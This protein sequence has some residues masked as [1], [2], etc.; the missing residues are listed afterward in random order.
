MPRHQCRAVAAAVLALALVA[1]GCGSGN[2]F[3]CDSGRLGSHCS[4]RTKEEDA[5]RALADH[6]FDRAVALLTELVAAEHEKDAPDY[7]FNTLLAAAY[8]GRGGVSVLDLAT[9]LTTAGADSGSD[10][11]GDGSFLETLKPYL[12]S[13]AAPCLDHGGDARPFAD[14]VAD[15][16]GAVSAA[17]GVPQAELAAE[18]PAA[19]ART[20]AF[21]LMLYQFVYG[22]MKL[23]QFTTSVTG[24]LDPSLLATMTDA[25]AL[26]ILD[27]LAAAG[28]VP[29][30]T[31][32]E[33]QAKIAAA[34]AEIAAGD[35]T[36]RDKLAAYLA[37]SGTATAPATGPDPAAG[38]GG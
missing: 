23:S 7:R 33:V 12:P 26:A 29:G 1:P 36:S 13:P 19:F 21:E 10:G 9:R 22:I 6:D 20:A 37:K 14:C 5:R 3:D 32:P 27:S 35:G 2:L 4:P 15:L 31:S 25:D 16:G 24:A 30:T 28:T 11:G 17:Q 18:A 34:H 8:A 38:S